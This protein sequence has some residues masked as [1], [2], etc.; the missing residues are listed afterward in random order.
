MGNPLLAGSFLSHR[1]N[2]NQHQKEMISSVTQADA[3][4]SMILLAEFLDEY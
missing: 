4:E 3:Y 1:L 2:G